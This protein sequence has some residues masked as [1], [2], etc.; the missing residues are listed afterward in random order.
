MPTVNPAEPTPATHPLGVRCPD[1]R[2]GSVGSLHVVPGPAAG[3]VGARAGSGRRR[4]RHLVLEPLPGRALRH[5]HPRILLQLLR[6]TATGVGVAGA[7][8][9][10][11]GDPAL[12]GA[13]RRPVRTALRHLV[14]YAGGGG[15]LR[16]G[17]DP[18]AGA[19]RPRARAVGAVPGHGYRLPVGPDHPRVRRCRLVRRP[20]LPHRPLAARGG[21]LRRAAGRHHRYRLL[22]GAVD[23]G[24]CRA[25]AP[26][27]GVPAHR[28]VLGAGAQPAG[29]PRTGG[30]NQ[31]GLRRLPRP[32]PAHAER[33]AF[34][35]PRATT[36]RRWPWTPPSANAS[37]SSAG[38]RAG[39]C[40]S[41]AS[42]T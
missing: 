33:P 36:P 28:P 16:R 5:R 34:A 8:P 14:Q 20:H 18:L 25:G 10:P 22:R 31:G 3:T 37:S 2:G 29:R 24:N 32:Q 17:G 23:S 21:G 26:T 41:A 30:R 9:Y 27:G 1:R 13:R 11:A 4:G 40:S 15:G 19:H 39:S 6:G 38:G 7:L 12:P 42:T 35:P